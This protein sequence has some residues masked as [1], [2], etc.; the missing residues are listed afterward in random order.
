MITS[1]FTLNTQVNTRIL[2]KEQLKE[3]GGISQSIGAPHFPS[4][5]V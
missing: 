4:K 1:P 2:I 5:L 3:I